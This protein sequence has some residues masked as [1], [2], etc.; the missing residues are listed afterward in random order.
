MSPFTDEDRAAYPE[1]FSM[2]KGV[3]EVGMVRPLGIVFEEIEMGKGVY[4]QELVEGGIA[5]RLGRIQPN[6]VLIGITAVKIVGAKS[7]RRLIPARNFDFDT[8]VG[9]IGSNDRRWGCEDVICMFERPGEGD[10]A[11][12]DAFM[13]FFEPPFANPW[14]QQQ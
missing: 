3:Y 5:E 2:P 8:V 9:A 1:I 11:E 4:V 12:I 6:D 7:E 10:R 13:E 14:K